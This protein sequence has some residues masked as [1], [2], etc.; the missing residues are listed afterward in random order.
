[1]R[2]GLIPALRRGAIAGSEGWHIAD[3]F[4]GAH[5]LDGLESALLR[6]A[7][8]P[9]ASLMEQLERDEHGL[10]RAVL[11]LLPSDQSELVL[12]IDQFE[13]VFTLVEDE[14]VRTHFLGSLEAAAND[15]RS[16]LRVVVTL[17]ADFYDR[18][19]L[20]RGFAELFKSRVEA[21]VPAVGR[22]ARAGDLGAGRNASTSR[23]SR[24]SS[25]RCW[26][27]SPRSRARSR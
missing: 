21:V 11:R 5:P 15:P 14:D 22:G 9:P 10:Y 7:P 25:P 20:Y 17:R 24:A 18:P 3:M 26:P 12:V 4:P 19:L 27:T 2:A 23:W 16:R 6:A 13:E 1:M 8:D